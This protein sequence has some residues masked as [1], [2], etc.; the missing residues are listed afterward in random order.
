MN[1]GIIMNKIELRQ[2]ISREDFLNDLDEALDL[3][4]EFD[5]L[6][7]IDDNQPSMVVMNMDEYEELIH[8]IVILDSMLAKDEED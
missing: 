8:G 2:L 7:I 1:G 4:Q 5:K 6:I 3:L